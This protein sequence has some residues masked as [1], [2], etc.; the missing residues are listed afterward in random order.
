MFA[1]NNKIS[2]NQIIKSN[3]TSYIALALLVLLYDY[4]S[5]FACIIT[6]GTIYFLSIFYCYIWEL[7]ISNSFINNSFKNIV[8][9]FQNTLTVVKSLYFFGLSLV[10]L[11]FTLIY[12]Y[13]I[14][15]SPFV[16]ILL[17]FSLTLI[18]SNGTS[19]STFRLGEL[20]FLLSIIWCVILCISF[21]LLSFS[22]DNFSNFITPLKSSTFSKP[23]FYIT[24]L[25]LIPFEMNDV[26]SHFNNSSKKLRKSYVLSLSFI[27]L[28]VAAFFLLITGTFGEIN[29]RYTYH[30]LLSLFKTFNV[31]KDFTGRIDGVLCIF[32]PVSLLYCMIFSTQLL[33]NICF[34][35]VAL[36]KK[37]SLLFTFL[38]MLI[39][40]IIG[41]PLISDLNNKNQSTINSHSSA[42]KEIVEEIKLTRKSYSLTNNNEHNY[43]FSH[44]NTIY[45]TSLYL[46][47]E[48]LL[49]ET[50]L[51][52]KLDPRFYENILLKDIKGNTLCKLYELYTN[53]LKN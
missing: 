7:F 17:I 16:F 43:D 47:N 26:Y 37:H 36:L 20:S 35:K 45:I 4:P 21:T 34:K 22:N 27:Y 41:T 24:L 52:F 48:D 3:Y 15:I 38:I 31:S 19:E 28:T 25:M 51:P 30:P 53:G 5:P 2:F 1:A 40:V 11:F 10:L 33:K 12:V 8:F 49:K 9:F 23:F 29:L 13:T 42:T 46:K 44:T 50:L 39:P 6:I 18:I 14:N 32:L